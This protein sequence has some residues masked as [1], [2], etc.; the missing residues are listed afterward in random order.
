MLM[1]DQPNVFNGILTAR[2]QSIAVV[3]KR[4]R[5]HRDFVITLVLGKYANLAKAN[6]VTFGF[7]GGKGK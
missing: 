1:C 2:A 5:T 4:C 3:I 6:N 7:L